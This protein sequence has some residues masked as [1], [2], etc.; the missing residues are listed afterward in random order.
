M[1]LSALKEYIHVKFCFRLRK[2]YQ[3]QFLNICISARVFGR[4]KG[5]IRNMGRHAPQPPAVAGVQ[6]TRRSVGERVS[7]R[8]VVDGVTGIRRGVGGHSSEPPV[9]GS[10]ND[11]IHKDF[12][13]TEH[14]EEVNRSPEAKC[15]TCRYLFEL[16]ELI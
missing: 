4:I 6:D 16:Y 9:D 7:L 5:S 10:D 11:N 12:L 13:H 2:G 14:T 1:V 15:L 8:P 3:V